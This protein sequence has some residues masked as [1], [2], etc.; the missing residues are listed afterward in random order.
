MSCNISLQFLPNLKIFRT[1]ITKRFK[2]HGSCVVT[3]VPTVICLG[4]AE[5][6]LFQPFS[7]PP[8]AVNN[9]G[10]VLCALK[11]DW[12]PSPCP[13]C[14]GMIK[15]YNSFI[16]VTIPSKNVTKTKDSWNASISSQDILNDR[17]TLP[18][19]HEIS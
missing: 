2:I 14:Y 11:Y 16:K 10:L 5:F 12:C 15:I 18:S 19:L 4:V 7:S 17:D 8:P 9:L 13:I 6:S 3:G 1:F